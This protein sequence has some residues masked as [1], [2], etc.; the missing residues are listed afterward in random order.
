MLMLG[1]V[2][3]RMKHTNNDEMFVGRMTNCDMSTEQYCSIRSFV[4]NTLSIQTD[5]ITVLKW[6]NSEHYMSV[7][8]YSGNLFRHDSNKEYVRITLLYDI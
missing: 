3:M 1:L 4:E 7:L 5:V 6:R 8:T 2:P